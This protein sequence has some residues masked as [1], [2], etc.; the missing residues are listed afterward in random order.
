M[1]KTIT[2]LL[3]FIAIGVN[4]QRSAAVL[5]GASHSAVWKSNVDFANTIGYFIGVGYQD[6][7]TRILSVNATLS[8]LTQRNTVSDVTF[9]AQSINALFGVNLYASERLY[10]TLGPEVGHSLALRLEGEDLNQQKD[11]RFSAVGG[12]A[13][14]V[15][16][17]V[18]V[19]G[20]Y[21]QTIDGQGSGFDYS[22]QLGMA[23]SFFNR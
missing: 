20:R 23:F 12:I 2:L 22:V 3:L 10:F 16:E 11:L 13:Y 9:S 1:K 15:I 5:A 7:V 4:A 21:H 19:F 6:K 18:A 14:Q 17:K 8:F